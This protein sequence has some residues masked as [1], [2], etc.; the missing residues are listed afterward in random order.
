MRYLFIGNKKYFYTSIGF[1]LDG[2]IFQLGYD[3]IDIKYEEFDE[4]FYLYN[5]ELKKYKVTRFTTQHSDDPELFELHIS[6]REVKLKE[7]GIRD[8]KIDYIT[9]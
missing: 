6:G 7:D 8:F 5:S 4:M 3:S 1:Y 2:I 9:K